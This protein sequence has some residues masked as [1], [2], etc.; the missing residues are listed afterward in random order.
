MMTK[1]CFLL[2]LYF[3]LSVFHYTPNNR[4]VDCQ[5]LVFKKAVF[6]LI[7]MA[8]L[9]YELL[10]LNYIYMNRCSARFG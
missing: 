2:R 4:F 7:N 9:S 10:T 8:F 1:N 3:S 5:D 6:G